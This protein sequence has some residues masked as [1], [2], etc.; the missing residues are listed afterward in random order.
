MYALL[1]FSFWKAV[2]N[3]ESAGRTGFSF[4]HSYFAL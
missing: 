2:G 4:V 3:L 1:Y